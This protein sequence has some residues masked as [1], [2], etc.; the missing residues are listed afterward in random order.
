[1]NP[2]T[3]R[4]SRTPGP[5]IAARLSTILAASVAL[6]ACGDSKSD[7]DADGEVVSTD[8]GDTTDT[9]ETVDPGAT[10]CCPLGT[11]ASTAQACIQGACVPRVTSTGGCYFDAQCADGRTCVGSTFC[12]CG[13]TD[14]APVVGTCGYGQG[15]CNGPD[16]CGSGETC[17]KGRCRA[18]PAEGCWVDSHCA[19]GQV[20]EG[21]VAPACNQLGPE[22]PGVC[23]LPGVCCLGDGEC[24][25]GV[26]R[27]GRCVER[28][29]AGECWAD[30]ECGAGQ[31]C[32]GEVTCP[33]AVGS[34]GTDSCAVL[35]T[36]GR[37]GRADE[38]CCA[39]DADCGGGEICVQGECGKR[40]SREA[41]ECWV[42]AHCGVGRVCDGANLCGCDEDGCTESTIGT[43][44][45]LR[46]DCDADGDCPTAMRCVEPDRTLC[47]TEPQ[48]AGRGVCVEVSDTGCWASS[49]CGP[50]TRCGGESVC[51]EA[52]GCVAANRPGTCQVLADR[53]DC[54]DSHAECAPGF[55]CR[56]Q[57]SSI[58]CPPTNSAVCLPIPEYGERCWNLND[59]PD[60]LACNRVWICGCNG[61]CY[62]NRIGA[63]EVPLF[64]ATDNE[65][66]VGYTC[67]REPE[68]FASPC[69]T[70]STCQSGGKCQVKVE[71]GCWSHDEC[72]AGNYCEGLKVCPADLEC[73]VPDQPGLCQPRAPLGECCTSF[74][75][76]QAGLRCVSVAQRTGCKTDFTAVCVPAIT[77]GNSCY[78]DDDCDT[79]QRCDGAR[80]CP[81]GV[82]TC[83]D[84]PAA[85]QC[86]PR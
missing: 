46:L 30:G 10:V 18:K 6:L 29:G 9:A 15:C 16:D 14:C 57:D 3:S 69:T 39:A 58:T 84:P 31:T 77:P 72:G 83:T 61:K 12:A 43:C 4:L 65:C 8:V 45:T 40:P 26:C 63:C 71:G 24:G 34:S 76:C 85:G 19:G 20:C 55:E 54:C 11:C 64:C 35:P 37:C 28:A 38:S 22:S 27:G 52:A 7:A 62:F 48:A 73:P 13:A 60:G 50:D 41:N 70:A 5:A 47:P 81:C 79:N 44:R 49:E 2:R 59:C 17:L 25:D 42:D 21:M 36:P 82:E 67:A 23:A 75:G 66:G 53:W 78:A 32:L 68:C 33:C 86:V 51:T 74:R 80:I 1:M 56:N